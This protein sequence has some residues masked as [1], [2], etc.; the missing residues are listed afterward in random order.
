MICLLVGSLA[1]HKV[2]SSQ[3]L[4]RQCMQR[5]HVLGSACSLLQCPPFLAPSQRRCRQEALHFFN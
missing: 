5:L 2:L 3:L 4:C 1:L